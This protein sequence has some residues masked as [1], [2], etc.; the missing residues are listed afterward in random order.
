MRNWSTVAGCERMGQC[1]SHVQIHSPLRTVLKP[2]EETCFLKHLTL[3]FI[4]LTDRNIL[5][6]FLSKEE[7]ITFGVSINQV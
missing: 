6:V 2:L 1:I 3:F 5:G 4:M 7:L